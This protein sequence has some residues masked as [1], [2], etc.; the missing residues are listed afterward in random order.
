MAAESFTVSASAN[1]KQIADAISRTARDQIP[2]AT[3]N[4]L[5]AIAKRVKAGQIDVMRKRLDRPT[6]FTLNSLYIAAARKTKLEARVWFKDYASKGTAAAKYMQPAVYG[7]GRKHK[8]FD[9]ALI[10]RGLMSKGQFA[11]PASGAPLDAYGNVP[12]SLYVKILSGL[13]AFGEQGYDANA[14]DSARSKR[15][16][17]AQRYFV[18]TIDGTPGIWERVKSAHGDGV[19]P[20]FVFADSSPKYRVRVPF[21]KIAENIHKANYEREFTYALNEAIRTAK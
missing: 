17:N 3:A 2:F 21:F 20:L 14:T 8:R 19:K 1:T 10:R 18:A 4:A 7:G 5:T 16:G 13:K 15:K 12:R 11:V 6:P 9:M